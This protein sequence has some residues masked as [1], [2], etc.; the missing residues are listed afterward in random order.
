[1]SPMNPKE[2]VALTEFGESV[3]RMNYYLCAPPEFIKKFRLEVKH[4][5]PVQVCMIPELDW[6]F[7]NRIIGLGIEAAATESILDSAIACLQDAGCYH[8]MALVSPLARSTHLPEWLGLRGFIREHNWAKMVRG[9]EPIPTAATDLRVE[10][11]GKVQA[12]AYAEVVQ[13]AFKMPRELRPLINGNV[14]KPGWRHYLAYDG[15]RPVSA[16]AIFIKGEIG[17]L[18]FGC[19][20]ESHRKRGGQAAL[21]ARRIQDGLAFG[22]KWF[23]TE[24]EED[25]PESPNPSYHNMF[26]SGFKPAAICSN[27]NHQPATNNT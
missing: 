25:T 7:F 1:M 19:T 20:L 2:I 14:G 17:W 6:S 27:Y 22:C 23:V 11:I 15:E 4:V 16:A 10:P 8:Y 21:L 3:A 5:G 18:G 26:S 12:D 13:T 9:N 24:T